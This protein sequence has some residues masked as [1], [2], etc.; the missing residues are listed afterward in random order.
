[1]D[2]SNKETTT[3]YCLPFAGG[4]TLS[5][6]YFLEYLPEPLCLCPI[7]LPGRGRRITEPLLT[8]LEEMAQDI[9]QQIACEL[10]GTRYALYGHRKN[11]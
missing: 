1:M 7:E 11:E 10:S 4:N 6:R 3:V 8:D 9:L 5:Y 2:I